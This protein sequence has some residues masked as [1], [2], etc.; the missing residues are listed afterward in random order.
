M[1]SRELLFYLLIL[2]S[3]TLQLISVGGVN[4]FS[5]LLTLASDVGIPTVD[6]LQHFITN[7]EDRA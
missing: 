7:S 5:P 4:A 2:F 3:F 1:T 6:Y